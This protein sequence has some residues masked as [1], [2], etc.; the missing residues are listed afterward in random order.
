MEGVMLYYLFVV[1]GVFVAS[2]SQLLLKE[3][4]NENH[5]NVLLSL[6]NWRVLLAY[7]IFVASLML[8]IFALGHGVN[9]KDIPILESLGYVFVPL[10]SMLI[11]KEK[12]TVRII[13]SM[14]MILLGVIVFYL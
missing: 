13:I 5:K 8:N 3:S 9:L 10:F 2:C 4:A 11:L 14:L 1:A 7:V 12:M 6:F